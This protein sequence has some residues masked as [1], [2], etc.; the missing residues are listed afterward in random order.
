[1][2]VFNPFAPSNAASTLS[3]CYREHQGKSLWIVDL[4]SEHT[5]FTPVVMSA[6]GGL[7]HEATCFYKWV[8]SLLCCQWGD[9]YSVVMGWLQCSLSFSLLH[10]A[11]QC[12]CG[13][14]SSI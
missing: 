5:C 13:A 6:T 11:I 14:H 12:V 4:E 3:A 2:H 1:M 8:A 10:S 9:E 7:A